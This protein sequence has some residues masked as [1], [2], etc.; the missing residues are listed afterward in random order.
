M[1]NTFEAIF[2]GNESFYFFLLVNA[3]TFFFRSFHFLDTQSLRQIFK[4]NSNVTIYLKK[5]KIIAKNHRTMLVT[6]TVSN[7][8]FKRGG[9]NKY[10]NLA[11]LDSIQ[12]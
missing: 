5:S 7:D 2:W 9:L 12:I 4:K 6:N 3:L 8:Y 10:A 1:R 11:E